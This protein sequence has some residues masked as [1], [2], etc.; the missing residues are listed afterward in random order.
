METRKNIQLM[1]QRLASKHLYLCG[2]FAEW[3]YYNM[4]VAMASAISLCKEL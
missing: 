3:E 2:R 4:D 1:R